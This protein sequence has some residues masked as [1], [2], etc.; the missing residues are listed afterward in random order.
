MGNHMVKQVLPIETGLA[1]CDLLCDM[2]STCFFF[3]LIA[4][5]KYVMEN[6]VQLLSKD[7]DQINLANIGLVSLHHL[8]HLV[9]M[10][11]IDL[12]QNSLTSVSDWSALQCIVTLNLDSNQLGSC[13]GME[14]LPCLEKLS[15][16]N[17]GK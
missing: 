4:G 7:S 6:A 2:L 14:N 16:R 9:T 17:N 15:L 5:S 3:V 11:T 8:E 12:S 1:R 13:A 10:T